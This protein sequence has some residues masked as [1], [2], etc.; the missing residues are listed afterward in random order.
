MCVRKLRA[1]ITTR[2]LENSGPGGCRDAV[3]KSRVISKA[4]GGGVSL[5]N[6]S[7]CVAANKGGT[8]SQ[9]ENKEKWSCHV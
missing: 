8:K 7:G 3:P 4:L 1:S 5:K 2:A 9:S 6:R